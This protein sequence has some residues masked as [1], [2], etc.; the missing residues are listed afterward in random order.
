MPAP[1]FVWDVIEAGRDGPGPR[2][3][4]GLVYD[5]AA[6]ATVLF[7]GIRW[8][9]DGRMLGDTWLFDGATWVPA[10][11]RGPAP[12]RY[13]AMAYSPDLGGCVLHGG[14]VDDVG[15]QTFGDAWV[16]L[17]GKWERLPTGFRTPPR[18]DHA[19]AYHPAA[20]RLVMAGGLSGGSDILAGTA[21]GWELAAVDSPRPPYQCPPMAWDNTLGGLVMHGGEAGHGGPQSDMTCVLRIAPAGDRT[22]TTTNV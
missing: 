4:H 10:V 21:T 17:G 7:G 1:A 19:L 16:F 18:D 8:A 14:A 12:R 2:S 13:P 5:P 22:I 20:G 9:G 3:R 11:G 15:R 6:R